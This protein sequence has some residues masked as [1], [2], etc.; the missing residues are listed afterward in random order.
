VK[1]PRYGSGRRVMKNPSSKAKK[2]IWSIFAWAIAAKGF[3]GIRSTKK[4]TRNWR[5]VLS[6]PSS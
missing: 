2:M 4:S 1:V 5:G 6:A 3:R